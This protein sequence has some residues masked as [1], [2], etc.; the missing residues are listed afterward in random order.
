MERAVRSVQN[1]QKKYW[2]NSFSQSSQ[3]VMTEGFLK[4]NAKTAFFK[5]ILKSVTAI[6][7]IKPQ[8]LN[9]YYVLGNGVG[10]GWP[11]FH[12]PCATFLT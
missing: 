6:R 5:A 8:F 7:N 4:P 2:D 1:T 12:I 10:Q 3:K 11:T 9:D